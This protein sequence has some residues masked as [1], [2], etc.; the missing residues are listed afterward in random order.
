MSATSAAGPLPAPAFW[1][2]GRAAVGFGLLAFLAVLLTLGDPG[3]TC[4]EPLDVSVGRRYVSAL[5]RWGEG[6]WSPARADDA[7]RLFADNAQHPPLGRLALGI[8]SVLFDPLR[9]LLGGS[10]V[11]SV[12]PARVAPALAF[13]LL[14]GIVAFA[15]AGIGGRASGVVAGIAL[16]MFP[17]SFAHAHFATLDTFLSLA[18]TAAILSVAWAAKSRRPLLFLPLT[19][20]IW[21]LALLTKIHAWVLPVLIGP[22]LLSQ[23]RPRR[24]IAGGLAW[25]ASGFVLFLAGWPWLW[26]D[27]VGRLRGFLGTSV[28]RLPLRVEYLG[29][30]FLDREVPWHYPWVYFLLT[31]PVGF[32][33]MGGLGVFRAWRERRQDGRPLLLAASV[34]LWLAIFSTRAPVYDGERLFLQVFPAWA[35]LAGIGAG[36]LWQ[37]WR[38]PAARL[39]LGLGI[40]LQG[41]GVL[42]LHPYQLSYYN[43]LSGGPRGA[44]ALGME[45]TYWGDAVDRSLLD[46]LARGG[47][48]GAQAAL[49]PTLHHIQAPAIMTPELLAKKMTMGDQS[50]W[51]EADLLVVYRRTA[52]WPEGLSEHLA[53]TRPLRLNSRQGVWLSGIW[54]GPSAT[55]EDVPALS[56]KPPGSD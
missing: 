28:E 24:A 49:L 25:L 29:G 8:A 27:P 21:G 19:G 56:G 4:D 10:D 50:R 6:R 45:L 54:P 53:A 3:I 42:A 17:R 20:L 37:S 11:F 26:H 16:L 44:E 43:L 47:N 2:S 35:I 33:A 52:Y 41:Y 15:A 38:R 36:A 9:E 14:V 51:R 32:L 31:I 55:P 13:G 23:L 34:L 1:T 12:F 5:E 46:D 40:A 7:S 30:V 18:W 39:A 48:P 22:Y